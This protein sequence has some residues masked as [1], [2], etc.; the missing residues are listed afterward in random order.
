MDVKAVYTDIDGTVTHGSSIFD[1]LRFDAGRRDQTRAGETFVAAL[2]DAARAGTPRAVTNR[3]YFR[4][5]AGRT[6]A[7]VDDTARAWL[8]RQRSDGGP[9]FVDTVADE[10]EAHLARGAHLVAVSA[11]F[12]P[13]LAAVRTRWPGMSL[14]TTIAHVRDGRYTGT[15]ETPLVGQAKADAVI[16]HA[17]LHG[18]DLSE[19]VGYGD[20][21]SDLPF[22]R[23]LG[24]GYLVGQRG[25]MVP[26][27]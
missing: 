24:S 18:V 5:W 25:C 7:D 1:L 3:R 17:Q 22:L 12:P 21:A 11:S 20:H 14:L 10:I 23:I 26:V 15:V 27:G 4:W 13:A 2:T 6:V 8:D 9:W 16:S 19:A